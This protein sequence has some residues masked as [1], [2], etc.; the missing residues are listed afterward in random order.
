[1]VGVL[2]EDGKIVEC[3]HHLVQNTGY[4]RNELIGIIGPVELVAERDRERA[5]R[6]FEK[7]K[8][9]EINLNVPILLKRKNGSVFPTIWSG[10]I[11][12]NGEDSISGYI[13]TGKDLS[14]IYESNEKWLRLQQELDREKMEVMGKT[15]MSEPQTTAKYDELRKTCKLLSKMEEKYRNLYEYL[16]DLVRSS[17]DNGTILDC[18]ANYAK[19]LGYTKDEVIGKSV[20]DH[21]SE[22]S[23]RE[24][25]NGMEEWKKTGRIL[26]QTIWL[27]RKDGLEFPALLSGTNLYDDRGMVVG[28]TVSL[29]DMTEIYAA[30]EEL[31]TEMVKRLMTIGQLTSRLTHDIRNPLTII[32]NASEMLK[33]RNQGMNES[34]IRPLFEM[35]DKSISRISY[36]IDDILNFVRSTEIKKEH[37]SLLEILDST[38]A[39]IRLPHNVKVSLPEGDLEVYCDKVKLEVIFENLIDNAIQAIDANNGTIT[40]KTESQAGYDMVEISDSGPGIPPG[41]LAQIFEPLFTTKRSGTGLGLATCKNLAEQHGWTIG[42]RLPS[43]FII[44]MPHWK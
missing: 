42:V 23:I 13:V 44:R 1:M 25:A 17:S 33:T 41:M 43:T 24:L 10:S 3:N 8:T 30:K 2:D 9:N 29:K 6:E 20:F 35:I 12:R 28:R 34:E 21:T 14:G 36:Q 16:P 40:I 15:E 19:T 4:E 37:C 38:L 22:R 7:V 39:K 5:M 27:R 18:N 26:V 11:L 31:E 32:H